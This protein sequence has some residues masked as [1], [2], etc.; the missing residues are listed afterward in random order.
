MNTK[1][2]LFNGLITAA[3]A[4]AISSVAAA[5]EPALSLQVTR[6]PQSPIIRDSM[7][8]GKVGVSINGPSLIRVPSWVA[9]PLGKYYLYF[10]HHEGKYLRL[11]YA[12]RVEGPWKI[13]EGGVQPLAAQTAV[14]NHI[15]SPEVIVDEAAQRIYLF[16]HGWVP[17]K[18]KAAGRPVD[19][20]D[21]QWTSVSVSAD[22]LHFDPLNRVVGP[23]YLRVF[24]HG[25]QW[26]ALNESG[27]LRRAPALGQR[28]EPLTQ[29]IGDEI[30]GA[31]DPAQLHEAGATPVDRRPAKG[32]FRYSIRHVGLDVAGDRLVV[33]F[34]CVSHRPERI[35]CTVVDLKGPPETWK[36]RQ[37]IEVL[38]P[39][40]PQE[41]ANLPLAFSR[42]GISLTYV[43]ELRDPEVFRDGDDVWLL[44][45]VAGEH[46][47]G[48]ARLS[49]QPAPDRP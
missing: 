7:L 17:A 22:G 8:P 29:L 16:Y 35:L 15:A 39:G 38:R 45:S 41:G 9:H 18:I 13:Y 25:G 47:I 48:L 24:A 12:D 4:L 46:G 30:I 11:A 32:P 49:Y 6:S 2:S 40:T 27:V 33:F 19:G 28:F 34:S 31:V 20:E 43:N 44:Y 37:T 3:V 36:A 5:S 26:F 23:S 14:E 1:L 10:A 42:G 21:G